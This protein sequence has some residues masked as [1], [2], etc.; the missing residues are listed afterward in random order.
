MSLSTTLS[1][2]S[3]L[4]LLSLFCAGLFVS[5]GDLRVGS[6]GVEIGGG[7]DVVMAETPVAPATGVAPPT[8]QTKDPVNETINSLI[9][10][11]NLIIEVITFLITPL[12][13]LAG[14][15]LSPD[16]TF[17][18]IFWLRPIL[19]Q[20]WI[21]ISNIVYVIFGFMLVSVAFANIF[22]AGGA[23][24][25]MKKMLPKLVI[26]MLIVPFTWFVVSATLSVVNI[27]TA[28]VIQLPIDT[29]VK[30]GSKSWFLEKPIIPREIVYNKN[31]SSNGN[32]T[33]GNN[34][35]PID[36]T[37]NK[38]N[39]MEYK[40]N[41][42]FYATDC[43]ADGN[44]CLSIR[45]FLTGGWGGAYNLLSVYA[46]GIFRIQ[47]YKNITP[48]ENLDKVVEIAKKLVFGAL[49]FIIFG[50]LV[51]A[52]VYALFTRALML[53][54]FAIFSPFFA[55][56]HV[57]SGSK[58]EA[59]KK[60]S[61]FDITHFISLALVPVFVSA[62]LA[63]GLMFLWL[64]MNATWGVSSNG[65]SDAQLKWEN[66]E[67]NT[68]GDQ[69]EF[70]FGGDGG[71]SLKTIGL[72]DA[73][74]K[75]GVS[76]ALDIGKGIIGTIIMN[77]L[78][79]VILWMAVMAA[80]SADEITGAAVKPISDMG[81]SVWELMQKAPSYIP[82]PWTKGQS[83]KSVTQGTSQIAQWIAQ[84][85]NTK[86]NEFSNRFGMTEFKELRSKITE[87]NGILAKN[88]DN[89]AA[90]INMPEAAK[91]Y[92]EAMRAGK[93]MATLAW[94]QDF[95][96]LTEAF[97]KKAWL[98]DIKA[99]DLKDPTKLAAAI[100]KIEHEL[101]QAWSAGIF[102]W[103]NTIAEINQPFIDTFI[104]GGTTTTPTSWTPAT[105]TPIWAIDA[106]SG[107][108]TIT[109][110]VAGKTDQ[111]ITLDKGSKLWQEIALVWNDKTELKKIIDW[112]NEVDAKTL[113]KTIFNK[114][115]IDIDKLYTAITKP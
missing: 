82:I 21:F 47:E 15:L 80:L 29:I 16:W 113:L 41:W 62:A 12:I 107:P 34:G 49:F 63:F 26:W 8:T 4:T 74:T 54:M 40:K 19:H 43:S 73:K 46:Y 110:K 2:L 97:A 25:E 66:V 103:K 115:Q 93:N 84:T 17:G 23:E 35:A 85:A 10:G 109:V 92:G 101:E 1:K 13:M 106:T 99:S 38:E 24:Y 77:I 108:Q 14:W 45:Q 44:D 64:V 56:N 71:I 68:T 79:L 76:G 42:N 53:W 70:K 31:M 81:N 75:D 102:H 5:V 114:D 105:W 37:N 72:L 96:D 83:L 20:L 59:L 67:I 3:R 36:P 94:Q 104:K 32:G 22:G 11:L 60:I 50:I 28:S 39:Y 78:A 65:W 27:L 18:E 57:L 89:K 100:A 48:E 87:T 61:K 111:I 112:K 9:I 98:T 95:L 6:S 91:S 90:N 7:V 88:T 30:S 58:S 55:L 86:A 52:I 69:T 51:I 33:V